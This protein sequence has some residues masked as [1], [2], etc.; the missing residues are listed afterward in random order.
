MPYLGLGAASDA[1]TLPAAALGAEVRLGLSFRRLRLE[2]RAAYW[3]TRSK[4]LAAL[5]SGDVPGATFT[6][7]GLGLQACLKAWP[8][9]ASSRLGLALCLGPEIDELSGAGFGV[10]A[11]SKGTR[12]WVAFSSGIEVRTR[13]TSRLNVFLNV[14]GVLPTAREHFA[15]RG[16]GEIYRPSA[17]AGRGTIGVA[18]DL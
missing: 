7:G 5:A 18:L 8:E 17:V 3:P 13:M 15:L 6:L 1:G 11:P 10:T 12:T 4:R 16:I 14:A 2:A 9:A